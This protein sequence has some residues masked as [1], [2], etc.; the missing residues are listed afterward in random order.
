MDQVYGGHSAHGGR[1][2]MKGRWWLCGGP[3]ERLMVTDSGHGT[4]SR[5]RPLIADGGHGRMLMMQGS[6]W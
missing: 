6:C 5:R 1:P 4:Y 2:T 3:C